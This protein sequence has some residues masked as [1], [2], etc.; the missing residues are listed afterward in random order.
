[1]ESRHL[2]VLIVGAGISG[3]SAAYHLQTRCPR[4]SYAILEGRESLGGTWDLFRY[5]GI[6]SDSDMYTLGYSFRPWTS[7]KAIADGPSILAYVR[8]TAE[9]Y[10]I[11][12]KIRYRHRVVRARWSSQDARWTVEALET[13]SGETVRFTSSF[14]FMCAGYYDYEEGY[15]PEL[16]GRERFRGRIVHPQKWTPDIEYAGKKVV[17]IGSGATAVTLV[18]ELSKRAAHVTMLQRSP[19]YV[20]SIPERDAIANWMREHLPAGVAYSVARWKNVI[21][22]MAFFSYCRRFPK[23]AS[24]L[25]IGQV[26][27][28]V[29]GK[30]D[31]DTHFTPPYKPWDQRLCLVPDGDLFH[32]LRDGRVTIVTDHIETFTETGLRLRSGRELDA[33]LVVTAT[34]LRLKFLG[35]LEMGVD[36]KRIEPHKTMAYKGM[37]CSD[38]PNLALAIGYTNASWTLKCDLT[39]EYVCRL[40]NYMDAHGYSH[41]CPRRNDPALKEEPLLDFSSGYVRRSIDEFPRQG[42]FAPWRVY[43]NYALDRMML[44]YGRLDDPGMVFSR[45]SRTA[46]KA[47]P[48]RP[49]AVK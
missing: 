25:I 34:G 12:R 37:M 45:P 31:V 47:P 11:D 46:R 48:S 41:C 49:A 20:V 32:A 21:L 23:S 9:A 15:T 22:A 10:G 16:S 3:I 19:S 42:S 8:E 7:P 6:R 36:G 44:K 18:P 28:M 33:D 14:L 29:R 26:K 17:V 4:K 39:S 38:V 43:Q 30:V 24:R 40:L 13:S 35:G 1:V 5:P 27:K 2:D